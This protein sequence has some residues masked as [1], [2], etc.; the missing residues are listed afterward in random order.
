M[1]WDFHMWE[2]INTYLH[3]YRL[4]ADVSLALIW[5]V[6]DGLQNCALWCIL[7]FQ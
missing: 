5:Q 6:T 7:G 3:T 4:T 2:S 1:H